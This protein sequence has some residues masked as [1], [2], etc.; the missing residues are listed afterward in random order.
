MI[1][2]GWYLSAPHSFSP[3]AVGVSPEALQH[4][5]AKMAAESSVGGKTLLASHDKKTARCHH[6]RRHRRRQVPSAKCDAVCC[7]VLLLTVSLVLV[8]GHVFVRLTL[9]Q[10]LKVCAGAKIEAW[11]RPPS[12]ISLP[13]QLVLKVDDSFAA[14][15]A[16]EEAHNAVA[17]LFA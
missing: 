12:I 4:L 10:F 2:R 17:S 1:S 15:V 3:C 11:K 16:D 14:A 13:E 8:R 6:R 5:H 7:C 9:K